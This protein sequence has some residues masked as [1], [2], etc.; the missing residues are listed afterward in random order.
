M[1]LA[2][3]ETRL[4]EKTDLIDEM[5]KVLPIA[6]QAP[7]IVAIGM[8]G[9]GKSTVL[10]ALTGVPLSRASGL[11]RPVK[12]KIVSDPTCVKEYV[13]VSGSDPLFK[14]DTKRLKSAADL[15]VYLVKL[16]TAG[17]LG[18]AAAGHLVGDKD[19]DEVS[20]AIVEEEEEDVDA[21]EQASRPTP[22]RR[23]DLISSGSEAGLIYVRVVRPSGPTYTIMD[24][25]G[26]ASPPDTAQEAYLRRVLE[27]DND[28]DKLILAVLSI[29][30]A[31]DHADIIHLAKRLDPASKRTIGV[32]TKSH[33]VTKNMG[34]VEKLQMNSIKPLVLPLG[35]VAVCAADPNNFA[36]NRPEIMQFESAFFTSNPL[37]K[38]LRRERWGLISLKSLVLNCQVR[39]GGGRK[40]GRGI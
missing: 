21:E 24:F 27:E 16:D 6:V 28:P 3:L 15:P 8:P 31:F 33:L 36:A 39:R 23:R 13:L 19:E 1:D 2:S 7:G 25:P 26:F 34:I 22:P 12:V 10:E 4:T 5:K 38:G 17:G 18:E 11:R 35:Y 32:V 30:H 20:D 37:L 14:H 40:G 9:A 29:K